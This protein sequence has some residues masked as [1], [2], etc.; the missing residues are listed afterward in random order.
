MRSV[1]ATICLTTAVALA[2][3]GGGALEGK[4]AD[5]P[6]A[7]SATPPPSG[8][9]KVTTFAKSPDSLKVDKIGGSDGSLKPD[10]TMDAAFT[11]DVEGPFVAVFVVTTDAAGTPDGNYQ[12]DTV[13]ATQEMPPE[14]KG[15][16]KTGGMTGGVGVFENGQP[17][18]K[19]DGSLPT[20]TGAHK[21]DLYV[22]N[23]G[24]FE[25]GTHF[26]VMVEQPD[27]TIVKSPVVT[28]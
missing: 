4:P 7:G 10:G 19:P 22:S 20:I 25:P 5:V 26:R 24:A 17:L 6:T 18:N 11:V 8:G 12:W 3:G 27:H 21:L 16:V 15:L 28:Y 23:T 9:A 2:C 14:M 1:L 13:V